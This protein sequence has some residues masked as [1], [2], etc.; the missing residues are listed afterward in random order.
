MHG[1]LKDGKHKQLL[2]DHLRNVAGLCGFAEGARPGDRDFAQTA[3]LAGLL[4]DL[5]KY[6]EEFQ[7]RRLQKD[8][9]SAETE[10]SIFGAAAA[11]FHFDCQATAF[12][13]AGHHAGLHDEGQLQERIGGSSYAAKSRLPSWLRVPKPVTNSGRFQRSSHFPLMRDEKKM[14]VAMSF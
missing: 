4:H 3:E 10:H 11:A 5:G 6:R 13:T 8:E 12:A 1:F 2:R 14:Y 7:I 9:K